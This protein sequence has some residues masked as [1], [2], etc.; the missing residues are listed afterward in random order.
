VAGGVTT[1]SALA[2]TVN[3]YTGT[4]GT[5]PIGATILGFYIEASAIDVDD[6]TLTNRIDWF[7]CKVVSGFA[8]TTFPV[9]AATGGNLKRRWIFHEEKGI[10]SDNPAGSVGGGTT[11]IRTR[12]FVKI[13]LGRRRMGEGDAWFIR[14]GSSGDY[15]V[16]Y[17]IIYKWFI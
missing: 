12:T 3:D 7:L 9:P 2:S 14:S 4:V 5:C 13:P 1:D 6:G 15:S 10:F 8:V 16:C 11:P 17:K